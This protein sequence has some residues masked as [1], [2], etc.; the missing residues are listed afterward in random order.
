MKDQQPDFSLPPEHKLIVA[1]GMADGFVMALQLFAKR[2][3]LTLAHADIDRTMVDLTA[4]ESYLAKHRAIAEEFAEHLWV[5]SVSKEEENL[6]KM[7]CH[8]SLGGSLEYCDANKQKVVDLLR[9]RKD[10]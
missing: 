3:G 8:I 1:S 6:R 5:L 7:A 2:Q 9:T 4:D 10:T